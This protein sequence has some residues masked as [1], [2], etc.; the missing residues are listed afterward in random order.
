MK[1]SFDTINSGNE[2][3]VNL[4]RYLEKLKNGL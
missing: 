4:F 3:M 1:F 2:N